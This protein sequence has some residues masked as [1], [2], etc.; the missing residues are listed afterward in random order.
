MSNAKMST[1]HTP[2]PWKLEQHKTKKFPTCTEFEI[3]SQ[4]THITTIYEHVDDIAVD[5]ANA[6]LI[7]AAPDLLTT[8]ERV[9]E[10]EDWPCGCDC[11]SQGEGPCL[12]CVIKNTLRK[13]KG[14]NDETTD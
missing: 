5:V 2:G 6:C 7:A 11:Y 9:Y 1:K 12:S 14:E 8:L 13:A 3:W 10:A 4:N